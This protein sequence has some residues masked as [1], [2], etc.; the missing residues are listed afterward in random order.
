MQSQID[1]F[2]AFITV[3]R[4]EERML[5][6]LFDSFNLFVFRECF[7]EFV[8]IDGRVKNSGGDSSPLQTTELF[9]KHLLCVLAVNVYLVST[10]KGPL[11]NPINEKSVYFFEE[12]S[13]A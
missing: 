6:F 4:E 12:S 1:I 8:E 11:F 5:N 9:F 3:E 7:I 10:E 13:F 2:F